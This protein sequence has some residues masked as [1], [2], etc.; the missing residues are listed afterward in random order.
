MNLLVLLVLIPFAFAD[1]PPTCD[2]LGRYI[3]SYEKDLQKKFVRAPGTECRNLKLE[4]LGSNI[5]LKNTELIEQNKCASLSV[6]EAQ[7][8]TLKNQEMILTGIDKLKNTIKDSK[9]QAGDKNQTVARAA[10]NTF[11]N[12]LNTAQSFELLLSSHTKEGTPFLAELKKI[13]V[14]KRNNP[15]DFKNAVKEI[16]KNKQ[17]ANVIDACVDPKLFSPNQ[18]AVKEINSLIA[19]AEPNEAQIKKWQNMLSIKRKNVNPEEAGYSFTQMQME[20]NAGFDKLDKSQKLSR[21]ELKVIQNLNDFENGNGLSFVEDLG[22]AKDQ[23]KSQFSTD[24]FRFLLE[25]ARRRQQYEIQSKISIA[26]ADLDKSKLKLEQLDLNDCNLAK[27]NYEKAMACHF[28]LENKIKD[29][30][31]GDARAHISGLLGPLNVSVK[32]ENKLGQVGDACLDEVK[33][34]GVIPNGCLKELSAEKADVQDKILQLN[35]LKER[36][37]FENKNLMTY[38]NFA[39]LKWGSQKCA[40]AD[41]LIEFCDPEDKISKEANVLSNAMMDISLVYTP[42]SEAETEAQKLCEEGDTKKKAE[43]RLCA[44][45]N[46][47]TSNI[48]KTDNHKKHD[49]DGPVT[50]PDGGNAAAKEKDAW[51]QG[52]TQLLNDILRS[53]IPNRGAITGLNSYPYNYGAYNGGRGPM[54]IAD[55][56]MF[57]ARYYGAYG[58]YMPTAG[59]QPYSAFSAST[60]SFGAYTAVKTSTY[61]TYFGK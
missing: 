13:P 24:R 36:I 56:I 48:V 15:T 30:L 42:K 44:F 11:V 25:D 9:A 19:Q 52:G 51:I 20:M 38:R 39:L 16:C 23:F 5:P 18:D 8:E 46:D 12:N 32:Y 47:T 57:N 33:T 58:Y 59:Y 17:E 34:Q 45:F 60:S 26:W 22:L 29:Q 28:I 55:T 37:G 43:E 54:G 35:L 27:D 40:V 7:L 53:Y 50:A 49:V 3:Q 41:S 2:E 31:T 61:P 14:D 4:D 21:D 6:I 10:G 1:S